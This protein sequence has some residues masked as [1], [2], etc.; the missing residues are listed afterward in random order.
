MSASK[1]PVDSFCPMVSKQ[2]VAIALSRLQAFS[3][4]N[5]LLEQYPT[6]SDV[7]AALLWEAHMRHELEGKEVVDL[8]AGTGVLGIGCL[9]LGAAHVTFVEVD[10]KVI[11][12][13]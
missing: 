9:L 5:V 7:A 11:P 6:E 2:Q 13:L 4:P 1:I 12:Q 10:P 8:G 3:A